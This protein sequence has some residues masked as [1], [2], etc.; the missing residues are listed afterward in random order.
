[1]IRPC[2]VEKNG[3][4]YAEVPDLCKSCIHQCTCR[5]MVEMREVFRN[6]PKKLT[7]KAPKEGR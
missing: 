5:I 6:L 7:L 4:E 3:Q 1:M 2:I